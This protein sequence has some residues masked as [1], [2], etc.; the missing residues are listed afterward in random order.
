MVHL[1]VAC[2]LFIGLTT[3]CG[4]TTPPASTDETRLAAS[5]TFAPLETPAADDSAH[6]QLTSSA[7]GVVL[8]WLEQGDT[9]TTLRFAER[10]ASGWSPPRTVSSGEEWFVTSADVPSVLR[11]KNGTLVANWYNAT[12]S[13]SEAYDIA[14]AYSRDDG[15]S[16]GPPFSPH[17]DG[18]R[19]QH[20][21]VTLVE[22]FDG[23]L[24]TL[25]LDGRGQALQATNPGSGSMALYFARFDDGF[26]QT[27]ESL[28]DARVCECC[29]TAAVATADGVLAAFRDRT[30]SDV[31][32]ITVARLE[33]GEWT[34]QTLHDDQW[35]IDACPVNGPALSARGRQV[36][37]AWFSA[38]RE[39]GG[40][41]LAFSIDE[42][43]TWGSP[44]RL[45]ES[46]PLGRVDVEVL[47]D[48]SAVVSWMELIDRRSHLMVR[49]V[50]PS[51]ER[52]AAIDVAG[53]GRPSGYPRMARFGTE[54]VLAWTDAEAGLQVKAAIAHLR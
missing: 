37:A 46:A 27:A 47:D 3:A 39:R 19:S 41:F 10:T 42:G 20:G 38:P 53:A 51:G 18:T 2:C 15:L 16:W 23:A 7:A 30:P 11:L 31:R 17:H 44:I 4:A 33:N 24:G 22:L 21:F 1:R 5:L 36:A 14:L 48:G 35:T 13:A 34:E 9:T 32:D 26:M 45:D 43:R 28:V 6:P 50:T 52:T 40:V 54:L 12:D 49:R 29:Q 25:W 8:S